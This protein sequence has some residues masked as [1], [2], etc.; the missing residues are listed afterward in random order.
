MCASCLVP[1]T[2]G[3]VIFRIA[4][5]TPDPRKVPLGGEAGAA[6]VGAMSGRGIECTTK[7][8][9]V[10]TLHSGADVPSRN[11][12]RQHTL[13]IGRSAGQARIA[14]RLEPSDAAVG[15]ERRVVEVAGPAATAEL[16][17]LATLVAAEHP[18]A[19]RYRD[20]LLYTSDAAD[21]ED[22]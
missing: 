1:G 16:A 10:N 22:S 6:S 20:C 7:Y 18:L 11:R 3:P 13:S 4:D 21:E 2:L 15:T 8:L 14:V 9:F 17:A 5:P 19:H 12:R